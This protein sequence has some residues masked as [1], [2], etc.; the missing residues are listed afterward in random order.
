MA[1]KIAFIGVGNMAGAII[2]GI[3]ASGA[4]PYTD[5]VLF[6][7]FEAQCAP[8]VAQGS[9]MAASVAEAAAMAD[10]VVLSVKPQNFP[11]ILPELAEVEDVQN[12]LFVTIA[13]GITVDER[14]VPQPGKARIKIEYI[15]ERL[16]QNGECR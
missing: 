1:R 2:K 14:F 13:A 8:Y 4:V 6:D 9:V 15:K 10:C 16:G 7:R 5:I 3:T 11:E 12:K